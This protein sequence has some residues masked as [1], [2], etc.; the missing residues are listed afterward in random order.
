MIQKR[1]VDVPPAV[2]LFAVFAFGVL[3]GFLGILLAAPLT[4]VVFVAVRRLYVVGMLGKDVIK[5]DT[6][7]D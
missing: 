4:V 6:D 7:G 1:A 5:R 2:L 3:F